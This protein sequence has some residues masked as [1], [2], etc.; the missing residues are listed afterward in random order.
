MNAVRFTILGEP[1]S[2]ANNRQRVI[3]K[4]KPAFIK[5]NKALRYAAAAQRQI[6]VEARVMMSGP[7]KVIIRAFYASNRSDLDESLILDCM[8]SRY[9][10]LMGKR[11]L[12][13][14]GVY[15]NDRQV[16]KKVIDHFIDKKNP[17][18]EIEVVP[19][20]AEAPELELR[21]VDESFG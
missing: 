13:R 11:L 1:A 16:K 5:S 15:V 8:Q 2:K 4:G 18:A 7:V 3:I 14:Q 12:T 21:Q 17:R 6:P 9:S 10:T 19:L 20:Y